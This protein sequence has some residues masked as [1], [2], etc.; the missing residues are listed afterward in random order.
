MSKKA[1]KILT[2]IDLSRNK[3][4]N[5]SNIEGP[6]IDN[7]SKDLKIHTNKGDLRIETVSDGNESESKGNITLGISKDKTSISIKPNAT[8]DIKD[9]NVTINGTDSLVLKSKDDNSITLT[10]EDNSIV[11]DANIIK[12]GSKEDPIKTIN[13]YITT[14]ESAIS[15][16]TL[17]NDKYTQTVKNL[18]ELTTNDVFSVIAEKTFEVL[19]G[20]TDKYEEKFTEE[21]GSYHL[22][23]IQATGGSKYESFEIVDNLKIRNSQEFKGFKFDIDSEN[24]SL[25]ANTISIGTERPQNT[26][27]K[28]YGNGKSFKLEV[29]NEQSE[30]TLKDLHTENLEISKNV[31]LNAEDINNITVKKSVDLK[32]P[33]L[34]L[35]YENE[36]S[37]VLTMATSTEGTK[38]SLTVDYAIINKE[39]TSNLKSNLSGITTITGDLNVNNDATEGDSTVKGASL[40]VDSKDITLG[41]GKTKKLEIKT[42]ENI[43]EET[44]SKT[45]TSTNLTVTSSNNNFDFDSTVLENKSKF[46]FTAGI[47]EGSNKGYILNIEPVKDTEDNIIKYE[48][49]ETV[50]NLNVRNS[51]TFSGS[52]FKVNALN[53]IS[54]DAPTINIGTSKEEGLKNTKLHIHGNEGKFTLDIDE[55]HSDVSLNN[56]QVNEELKLENKLSF[57]NTINN[58]ISFDKKAIIETPNLVLKYPNSKTNILEMVSKGNESPTLTTTLNVDNA[59]IS[60]DLISNAKTTLNTS[61]KIKDDLTINATTSISGKSLGI[62]S[63]EINLGNLSNSELNINA[64]TITETTP[65]KTLSTTESYKH[66]AKGTYEVVRDGDFE[67][68][69]LK[70]DSYIKANTLT[71]NNNV[72]I[73]SNG[74]SG[75]DIYWDNLSK[76]LVFTRW[77]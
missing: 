39:L 41:E 34:T 64:K 52:N 62:D 69:A 8:V 14:K 53:E 18:L 37:N 29:E 17:S 45:F 25:D 47:K 1:Y 30:M 65:S 21:K 70:N 5:V 6:T 40:T 50:D 26:S 43:I 77:E 76:S 15:T 56:L 24:I 55:T 35:G 36:N 19:A 73:G 4:L 3:L 66:T 49:T 72:R 51:Q 74:N 7:L 67:I 10:S 12:I 9:N 20:E 38:T 31:S 57:T 28:I 11:I 22:S 68:N 27:L 42:S 63:A 59:T 71:A 58:P 54:L 23:V 33:N 46:E 60:K 44:P 48:S 2:D 61:T 13:E 32:T 75:V 16:Q